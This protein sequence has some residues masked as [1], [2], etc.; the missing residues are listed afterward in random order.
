MR[1]G[2]QYH[3][4]VSH[5]APDTWVARQLAAQ[6]SARGAVPFLDEASIAV[7]CRFEEEI[8]TALDRAKEVLVLLTPWTLDR[9]YVWAELGAAWG[10]RLPIVGLLHGLTLRDLQGRPEVPVFIK[11]RNFIALNDIDTYLFQLEQRVVSWNG[12][13]SHHV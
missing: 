9:P 1:P 2:D 7:G 5:S 4:F 3:V 11:E 8:L 13:G 12:T 10:K 6:L